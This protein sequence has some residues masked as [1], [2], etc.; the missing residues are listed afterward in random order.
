MIKYQSRGENLRTAEM[1]C[2]V[3]PVTTIWKQYYNLHSLWDLQQN[4][5]SIL[6]A[7][8]QNLWYIWSL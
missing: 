6:M 3:I 1:F 7:L 2:S 4:I 8:L 5:P